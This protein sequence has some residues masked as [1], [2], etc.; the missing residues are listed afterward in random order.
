MTAGT[1]IATAAPPARATAELGPAGL[2]TAD[3][4]WNLLMV[5]LAVHLLA[6]VGRWHQLFPVLGLLHPALVSGVLAVGIMLLMPAGSR[7][8]GSTLALRPTVWLLVLLVWVALS[9]PGALWLGGAA[10]LLVNVF[11]KLVLLYLLLAG[12][13][14]GVRDVERLSFIYYAGVV[15]YAGVVLARYRTG[16]AADR[17][18]GLIYYDANDFAT[19]GVTALPLGLYFLLGRQPWWRR[20]AA[21]AGNTILAVAF[22]WAGSRGGFLALLAAGLYILFRFSA[23]PP[24]RRWLAAAVVALLF[25]GTA[26][27]TFWERMRSITTPEGDYNVTGETGRLQVWKRGVGYMVAHPIFGVGADNFATAEGTLSPLADAAARGRGA[28]WS[29]AHNTYV[30]VGAE[31]GVPGLVVFLAMIGTAL[32]ALRRARPA[33]LA[34][35]LTAALIGFLVGALFLSFAYTEMLYALLGLA[36]GL[37]RVTVLSAAPI[38]PSD[39]LHPA[40]AR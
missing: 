5:C 28:K 26:S 35:A 17:L 31:L 21:A 30:Q 34:Q 3:A 16:G 12:G 11:L 13:V 22:V 32:A 29:V 6:A 9:V 14:R 40:V 25:L 8:L 27:G 20:L 4:R 24:L 2:P 33:A 1:L 18:G 10:T 15:V 36:V 7:S 37:R 19:L 38:P 39:T 23:V